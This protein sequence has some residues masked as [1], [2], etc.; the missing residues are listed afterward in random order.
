MN[1]KFSLVK[2]IAMTAALV[3]GVSGM[4]CADDNDMTRFGGDGYAAPQLAP[5]SIRHLRHGAR[6]I[7]MGSRS[8]SS[9]RS[10][11]RVLGTTFNA[12]PSTSHLRHGAR[13]IRM[14][15]RSMNSQALSSE[16]YA[17]HQPTS[18][19]TR[20]MASTNDAAVVAKSAV[21]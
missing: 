20:A 12:S 17:W 19:P 2:S 6:P 16:A 7:R 13:P 15:F 4:A 11:P 1:S 8:V 21:K 5:L 3:A 10:R 14:A 18:S 9:R